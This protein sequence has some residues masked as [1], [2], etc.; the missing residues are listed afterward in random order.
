M[1]TTGAKPMA[2]PGRIRT[3]AV[4]GP[5]GAGKSRFCRKLVEL[6]ADLVDADLLGHAVLDRADVRPALVATFGHEILDDTGRVHR[7]SLG[8]MVFA[9]QARRRQLDALVHPALAR[10]CADELAASVDGGSP[11]VI[12]EA[13]VYFLLPGPPV[14]DMTVTVTAPPDI[15]LARLLAK[16]LAEDRARARMAAQDHLEAA[17]READRIIHNDGTEAELGREANALWQLCTATNAREG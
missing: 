5:T 10:T 7:P 2:S 3:V 13:A 8:A 6:G 11:L 12:L 1:A 17:W 4:T 9:D 16:G 14:V 15:R